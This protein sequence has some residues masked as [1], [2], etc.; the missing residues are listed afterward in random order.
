MKLFLLGLACLGLILPMAG[1]AQEE[2]PKACR[3]VHLWYPVPEGTVFYNEMTVHESHTGSYF[4]ACGFSHGYFGIQE[5]RDS[6]DKVV[7]FS[8]WDPGDQNDPNTVPEDRKV[9]VLHE[10][11][12]V[13]VSRF[14]NEGTGGKSMFPYAWKVGE[15]YKFMV[16]AKTDGHRTTYAG[17]FYLNDKQEWKHLVSFN[18]IS[19]GELLRGYYSF[20]EDFWRNGVSATQV[21]KAA[22]GNGWVLTKDGHWVSLTKARF[23]ADRST[24][25]DNI[26]AGLMENGQFFLQTGGETKNE[27]PLQ[28]EMSRLP[29]GLPQF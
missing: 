22:Y 8:V 2:A 4:M 26:N 17:Y 3:S 19:K 9:Q 15:T 6:N 1:W 20:V 11:E 5:I 29:F 24:L 10:G 16:R 27:L 21:H 12:G 28:S 25:T 23:T 13:E 14:G 7:I 18:T